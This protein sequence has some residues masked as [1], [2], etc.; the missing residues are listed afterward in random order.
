MFQEQFLTIWWGFQAVHVCT[1]T[2]NDWCASMM[3]RAQILS[4][5][6]DGTSLKRR[7]GY[8]RGFLCTITATLHSCIRWC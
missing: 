5:P 1:A 8:M 2:R 3:F 4:R 6:R 7:P